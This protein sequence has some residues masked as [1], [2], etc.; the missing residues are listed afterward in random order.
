[1]PEFV[2]LHNHSDFSLQDG[3]CRISDLVRATVDN[4]MRAVALTDHGVLFGAI[5]FYK[6]AKANGIKPIIGMEAYVTIEGD[7]FSRP[8]VPTVMTA[9]GKKRAKHYNHLVL[10]AKN[11]QGFKNLGILSTLGFTEGYYFRPR[12]DIDII[13]K[14]S[15]GLIC[16]SACAA[17]V[18]AHPLVNN[19]YDRAKRIAIKYKEIFGDDFYLELQNHSMDVDEYIMQ[20]VPKI[21]KEID[22]KLIATNDC[23]Y[24]KPNHAIPHNVLMKISES[25]GE[26]DYETLRY[27]TDQIYFKN[28]EEMAL[29]FRDFPDAIENT[30][31]VAE[32]CNLELKLGENFFP[33]FPIPEDAETDSLDSYLTQLSYEG[34]KNKVEKISD[35][36]KLRL[37]YELS[38]IKQMGYS[39]YFLI[40]QDF[41]RA[42]KSKSI[43]VGPGRGSAAGSLVS[44][45]LDITNVNPLEYGLLFERFLNPDRVSM[46]DIDCDFADDGREE[47]IQYVREKY[48]AENVAQIITFNRLSSRQIINDVGRVLNLPI[49]EVREITKNIPSVFGKVLSINQAI[50]EVP[51]LS[52]LKRPKDEQIK[53]LIEYSTVL[54][55]LNRNASVHAAGVVIAPGP[56]Q[57]YSPLFK[58]NDNSIVT[59]YDM[60]DLEEVGLIKMDILGL[61]TLTIIQKSLK[62]IKEI[63]NVDIDIEKIPLDDP[64]TFELFGKGKTVGVFQFDKQHTQEYLKR[65]KPT[66]ISELSA[67]NALNRPG[68]MQY[69]DEFIDRKYGRKQIR[70]I[71]P[72]LEP[73]L[74]ETYGI[75]VY[76]EQVIRIANEIVGYSL[77]KADLM[78]RAMGKKDEKFMIALEMEFIEEGVK[79]G[80][81]RKIVEEIFNEIK[82]FKD[83]GFNKSHSVAYSILAFQTAYLKARYPVEF[84]AAN[85]C[86]NLT[87][88]DEISP[89]LNEC[90]KMHIQV[91]PPDVNESHVDFTIEDGAIRFGLAAIKNVGVSA[92]EDIVKARLEKPFTSIFDF[93]SRTDTRIVN[94][95]ALEGLILAGAFDRLHRHRSQLFHGVDVALNYG[96]K[97]QERDRIGQASIFDSPAINGDTNHEPKLPNVQ[98]WSR[99]ERLRKEREVLGF[100]ISGHPLTDQDLYVR[101]FS[102][103]FLG[104]VEHYDERDRAVTVCVVL[105]EIT[106]RIYKETK[107]L[108]K[109]KIQ[110]LTGESEGILFDEQY[111]LYQHLLKEYSTV[112]LRGIAEKRGDSIQVRVNEVIPVDEAVKRLSSGVVI[113]IEIDNTSKSSLAKLKELL[114]KHKGGLPVF[115]NAI[116]KDGKSERFVLKNHLISMSNGILNELTKIFP[117]ESILIISK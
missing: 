77:A 106:T 111:K 52:F 110:D 99:P 86:A 37:E 21:A 64:K 83:Y 73:I 35:D 85:M 101:S 100:Y 53:K 49:P 89:F 39:G 6:E 51:E 27:G 22:A 36:L 76:Q 58:T 46:P 90:S 109:I 103:I 92:V 63:Y 79:N 112:I 55:N 94:K 42:A 9:S 48:G 80:L 17:G 47:I 19:D 93:C 108:A 115:L 7:R 95:R 13:K 60:K 82:K 33:R 78:R 54:E 41:I 2:H 75:I 16:L 11:A 3:A 61:R 114:I 14:Y 72:S 62:F 10:I 91:L 104:E 8:A 32:K 113:D 57:E 69:I 105:L 71:H 12:I 65:L 70:Y 1:M 15:E 20:G 81:D 29:L 107:T 25:R 59:Q 97:K 56:I 18:V 5:E 4:K 44:Y 34:L 66:S 68:P 67:M 98:T 31:E 38:V 23:H 30:L 117:A 26:V 28:S 96:Q 88:Q 40:V 43:A 87:K 74:K 24:I 116:A 45:A 84:L 102:N 50:K